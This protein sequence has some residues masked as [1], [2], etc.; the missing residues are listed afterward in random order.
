MQP[1]DIHVPKEKLR[2][3][4]IIALALPMGAA[5]FLGITLFINSIEL[6]KLSRS[7]SLLD[8]VLLGQALVLIPLAFVLPGMFLLANLKSEYEK[9]DLETEI[10]RE[11]EN[12]EL[13]TRYI[14]LF[15]MQFQT[16]LIISL[17]LLEGTAMFAIVVLLIEKSLWALI[18]ACLLIPMM[19]VRF[20]TVSRFQNTL[21]GLFHRFR[22]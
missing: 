3:A 20:P 11:S 1:F 5:I 15:F 2:V 17:A 12:P 9:I 4:Q 21:H 8:L 22:K 19:L 7:F 16:G 10:R 14:D 18:L 13:T 6:G